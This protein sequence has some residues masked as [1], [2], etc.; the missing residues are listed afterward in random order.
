[1]RC[2]KTPPGQN[3]A[4]YN[5]VSMSFHI[6]KKIMASVCAH[7][8]NLH[9]FHF[10]KF[11]KE[12]ESDLRCCWVFRHHSVHNTTNPMTEE[13][14]SLPLSLQKYVY[15]FMGRHAVYRK[16]KHTIVTLMLQI[17]AGVNKT[18]PGCLKCFETFWAN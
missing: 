4:E 17:S 14:L 11:S 16:Q 9:P 12:S 2:G 5:F 6:S 18:E 7:D 15:S 10:S 1:M 3:P 13:L 8:H